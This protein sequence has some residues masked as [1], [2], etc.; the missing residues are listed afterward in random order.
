MLHYVSTSLNTNTESVTSA[1]RD[2]PHRKM[3]I[4]ESVGSHCICIFQ[5]ENVLPGGLGTMATATFTEPSNDSQHL[6]LLDL[7]TRGYTLTFR[8]GNLRT[9][10]GPAGSVEPWAVCRKTCVYSV[11]CTRAIAFFNPLTVVFTIITSNCAALLRFKGNRENLSK[12]KLEGQTHILNLHHM[13]S[14][15]VK[16]FFMEIGPGLCNVL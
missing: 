10:A 12:S 9:C 5:G 1:S 11:S 4:C 2:L 14:A 15:T 8:Q 3:R 13:T 16:F 7:E 6:A